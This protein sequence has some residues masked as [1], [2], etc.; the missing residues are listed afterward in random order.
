[1]SRVWTSGTASGSAIVGFV[2]PDLFRHAVDGAGEL[3]AEGLRAA[4]FGGGDVDPVGAVLP[5]L[6]EPPFGVAETGP[7]LVEEF[8]CRDFPARRRPAPSAASSPP[9]STRRRSRRA[10]RWPWA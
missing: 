8:T 1:M 10:A 3:L 9:P 6:E 2:Q 4:P 7:G 5:M